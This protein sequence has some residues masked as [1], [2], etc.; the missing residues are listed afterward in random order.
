MP[1]GEGRG[2]D[3]AVPLLLVFLV[4]P[5]LFVVALSIFSSD[6]LGIGGP[7]PEAPGGRLLY[8]RE[9]RLGVSSI[10]CWREKRRLLP[11]NAA[12]VSTEAGAYDKRGRPVEALWVPR[13]GRMTFVYDGASVPE[14]I[15]ARAVRTDVAPDPK[16]AEAQQGLARRSGVHLPP[17][18]LREVELPV[19]R[20]GRRAKVNAEL[21]PGRY[22]VIVSVRVDDASA[23]GE[24]FYDFAVTV[25]E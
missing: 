22:L 16:L 4:A 12:C 8:G 23:E 10:G 9:E 11:D 17:F 3:L 6:V 19:L 13:D 24:A 1:E 15:S 20:Q 18:G 25:G 21:E 14:A 7:S 2:R 5:V